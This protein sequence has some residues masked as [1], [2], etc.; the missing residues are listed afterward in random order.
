MG[1]SYARKLLIVHLKFSFDWASHILS[2]NPKNMK[3]GL[4]FEA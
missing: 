3:I 4:D 1:H 2:S